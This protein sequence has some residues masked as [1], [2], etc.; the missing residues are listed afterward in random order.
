MYL[1]FNYTMTSRKSASFNRDL[2]ICMQKYNTGPSWL[3]V[4]SLFLR[5]VF[6]KYCRSTNKC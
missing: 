6:G 3:T 5:N 4:R 1:Y 2:I